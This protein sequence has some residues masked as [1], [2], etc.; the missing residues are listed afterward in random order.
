MRTREVKPIDPRFR[1]NPGQ[2]WHKGARVSR[3]KAP[4]RAA[5]KRK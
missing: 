4:A 5:R 2:Q 1:L 3:V